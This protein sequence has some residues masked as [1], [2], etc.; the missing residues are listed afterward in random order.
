MELNTRT[1]TR[2]GAVTKATPDK[3]KAIKAVIPRIAAVIN[4]TT[5]RPINRHTVITTMT[6]AKLVRIA[7]MMKE[8]EKS[9]SV[10]V[11]T[12]AERISGTS[13]KLTMMINCERYVAVRGE[14]PRV[15]NQ[16]DK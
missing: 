2:T 11:K 12:S 15:C 4:A 13:R 9:K 1:P 10:A 3:T 6:M 7:D 16:V 8:T 14:Q 5:T